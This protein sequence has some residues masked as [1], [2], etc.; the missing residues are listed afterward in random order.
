VSALLLD[1]SAL[2]L[3]CGATTTRSGRMPH[4]EPP[5][6]EVFVPTFAAWPAAL[7]RAAPP[8]R[9]GATAN[10][11]LTF[12]LDHSAGADHAALRG[13]RR[14]YACQDYNAVHGFMDGVASL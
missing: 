12:H 5:A 9:A 11:K 6:P 4:L 14:F 8:G 2:I 13:C 1:R 10:I 3:Q 7:R